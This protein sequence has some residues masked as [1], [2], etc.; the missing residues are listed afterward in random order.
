MTTEKGE[1][2]LTGQRP[3]RRRPTRSFPGRLTLEEWLARPSRVRNDL[4]QRAQCDLL[5]S[6]RFCTKKP[7]RRERTC[8]ATTPGRAVGG[9]GAS[10][11][12]SPRR[13]ETN[14]AG[15]RASNRCNAPAAKPAP[16]R[17]LRRGVR[18][19]IRSCAA[20]ARRRCTVRAFRVMSAPNCAARVPPRARR[21]LSFPGQL[22]CVAP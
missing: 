5:G 6:F 17:P 3:A 11:S 19:G 8:W 18:S 9:F 14:G 1:R 21:A 13:C 20:P 22:R 10:R 15:S 7:C 16:P 2:P 12:S 4:V